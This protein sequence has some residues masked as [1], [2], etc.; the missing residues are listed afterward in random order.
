MS[1]SP[2]TFALSK[3]SGREPIPN[4][5]L[6]YFRTRNRM[7]VFSLVQREFEKQN[8]TQS[9]LAARINKG[10]DRVC[11]LLGAPGNWTLDTVS[12]LLFAMSGAEVDYQ[13]RY[14]LDLMPRNMTAPEWLINFEPTQKNINQTSVSLV[15]ARQTPIT[16]GVGAITFGNVTFTAQQDRLGANG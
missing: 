4:G 6:E 9:E 15:D 7:R 14:P 8:I 2:T 13:A 16:Q 1:T 10:T 3:P 12:D 5:V 11:H